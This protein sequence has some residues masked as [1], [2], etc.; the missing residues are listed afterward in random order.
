MEK[1]LFKEESYQIIGK[2]IEVHNNI[3][4]GFGSRI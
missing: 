2:C 3:G 1:I 4:A